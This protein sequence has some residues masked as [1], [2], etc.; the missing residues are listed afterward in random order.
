MKFKEA[1]RRIGVSRANTG[2]CVFL[3][4]TEVAKFK[5]C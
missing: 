5:T 2:I 3:K 4:V 1:R